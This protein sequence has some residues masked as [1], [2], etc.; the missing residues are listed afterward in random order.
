M[1]E[2]LKDRPFGQNRQDLNYMN[3][4]DPRYTNQELND[5]LLIQ[6]TRII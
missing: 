4:L 2:G 3:Q 5:H 1:A 6:Y